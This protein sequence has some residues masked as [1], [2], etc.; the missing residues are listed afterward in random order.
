MGDGL[1]ILIKEAGSSI[2][3][4]LWHKKLRKGGFSPLLTGL[5]AEGV[6]PATR[7]RRTVGLRKSKCAI[8][9]RP[10]DSCNECFFNNSPQGEALRGQLLFLGKLAIKGNKDV[11]FLRIEDCHPL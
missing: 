1:K 7:G 11:P 8:P 10:Y 6:L 2:Y 4:V 5:S 9:D 3:G